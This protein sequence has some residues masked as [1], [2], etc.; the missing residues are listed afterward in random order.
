M[1]SSDCNFC[2]QLLWFAIA[3]HI[4][5]HVRIHMTRLRYMRALKVARQRRDRSPDL[6][7]HAMQAFRSAFSCQ[8][9]RYHYSFAQRGN[10]SLHIAVLL[11]EEVDVDVAIDEL[12]GHFY[13]FDDVH[14]FATHCQSS[15]LALCNFA[16]A[17][18]NHIVV[19]DSEDDDADTDDYDD[20]FADDV[21]VYGVVNDGGY[22]DVD[23]GVAS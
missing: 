13:D 21:D 15:F 6:Y 22:D 9:Y 19:V 11:D 7:W 14:V 2:L 12:L 1:M 23:D 18:V 4:D 10:P 20:D 17:V 8:A 16:A 5:S 3:V